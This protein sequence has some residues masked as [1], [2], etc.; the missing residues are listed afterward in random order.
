MATARKHKSSQFAQPLDVDHYLGHSKNRIYRVGIELEGGWEKL[1]AGVNLTHDGSVRVRAPANVQAD[2][3]LAARYVE[4]NGL[5][6][7]GGI[8]RVL[9]TEFLRLHDMFGGGGAG[10]LHTGEIPSPPLELT[11]YPAW[12]KAFYPHHVNETCG[13]HV[14]LSF[15]NAK[16]YQLLMTPSY[17]AT[18]VRYVNSWA[19]RENLP[20]EHCIWGRIK[21]KS[22]YCQH[23]FYADLQARRTEKDHD[24]QR[25]GN[26]YTV[27]NY[28][29]GIHNTAE[30]RILPMMATCDLG[31]S[32]VKNVIDV[33]N[34]FLV[35]SAKREERISSKYEVDDDGL[36]ETID[37]NEL[38]GRRIHE[39]R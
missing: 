13:L 24:R 21:G 23:M 32:A 26:R 29:Y 36:H 31:I 20:P 1:P 12:M 30:C 15:E 38:T 18:I 5:Y 17:P 16:L 28:C 3:A 37:V 10:G 9:M 35:A 8:S 14:H 19:T 33:T 34:A 7:R 39:R 25:H 6:Q 27:I 2:P 11:A 22:E 4:L